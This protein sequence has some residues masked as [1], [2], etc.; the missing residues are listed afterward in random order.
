MKNHTVYIFVILLHAVFGDQ[1]EA[2]KDQWVSLKLSPEF[3]WL[4]VPSRKREGRQFFVTTTTAT[5]TLSTIKFC[6]V[7]TA[8]A[9][10]V[11][12]CKRDAR[13]KKYVDQQSLLTYQ[14]S[15]IPVQF[16]WW[17]DHQPSWWFEDQSQPIR[18]Q[19]RGECWSNGR[20]GNIVLLLRCPE[21][22]IP[23][24]LDD[25]ERDFYHHFLHHHLILWI[26]PMYTF[27]LYLQ[28][29]S[30]QWNWKE[31]INQK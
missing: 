17:E 8:T 2:E 30:S 26:R 5:T 16:Y 11:Y 22:E 21:G 24:L 19:N 31:K 7:Q 4:S 27:G 23:Q 1:I 25:S 28:R 6:W 13:L 20:S 14:S 12:R 10:G 9:T 15:F 29:L 18:V 3:I